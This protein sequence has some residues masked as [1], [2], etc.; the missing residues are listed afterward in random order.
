MFNLKSLKMAQA[1]SWTMWTFTA[2]II[3]F[4]SFSAVQYWKSGSVIEAYD[5]IASGEVN[6]L[7]NASRSMFFANVNMT[8]Y[9]QYLDSP[10]EEPDRQ[11]DLQDSRELI[12][13]SKA[14]F[15]L[16]KKNASG[17]ALSPLETKIFDQY[18]RITEA[19]EAAYA[20]LANSNIAEFR[21]YAHTAHLINDDF[22]GSLDEFEAASVK[23]LAEVRGNLETWSHIIMVLQIILLVLSFVLISTAKKAFRILV[24][25]PIKNAVLHLQQLAKADLSH[26]IEEGAD[27]E[28]GVL[29]NAMR[30]TQTSLSQIVKLVREGTSA[31][32]ATSEEISYGNNNLASRTEQQAASLQE[33]AASMDEITATVSQN[34]SNARQANS[35]ARDASGAAVESRSVVGQV[36]STMGNISESSTK[37]STIVDVIEGIAF[38]TNIL[39][40]NAAVEAARA[41]E[42]GRGFA[43]VAQEVRTL[44]GRSSD[45]AREIKALIDESSKRVSEGYSQVNRAGETIDNVV[46]AVQKVSDIVDEITAASQEQ[47]DGIVQINTAISQMDQVTQQ[48][49]GLVQEVAGSSSNLSRLA[50]ELAKAVS[51]FQLKPEY[52]SAK[53]LPHQGQKSV[54]N[55]PAPAPVTAK[56]KAPAPK[57]ADEWEEF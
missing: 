31:I 5:E 56:P 48:N 1:I 6:N 57:G 53:D 50:Q 24:V 52:T 37:I 38:Q 20:A 49:S 28:A 39:A 40:L 18:R 2:I 27:N 35:L 42:Q 9:A 7:L 26:N 23:G 4:F 47:S 12:D 8:S 33:T 11:R 45:A 13:K 21:K 15:D 16:Y 54:K 25:D 46:R 30:D 51:V 14:Y 22:Q 43:V 41:G 34:A 55:R 10:K 44:A 36:V 32:N 19:N 29:L 3:A 17:N